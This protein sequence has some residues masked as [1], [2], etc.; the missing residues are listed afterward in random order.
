MKTN[1][2]KN[3][4]LVSDVIY[5]KKG[6]SKMVY[7]IEE[8][9]RIVSPIAAE[10]GLDLYDEMVVSSLSMHIG[11]IGEQLDKNKLSDEVQNRYEDMLPWSQI[12]KFR[13]K[14]YHHYGKM[15]N[16]EIVLIAQESIPTLIEALE[17]I[18]KEIKIELYK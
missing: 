13:D 6:G 9:K 10:Y 5:S 4:I 16:G 11:Q 1:K 12:K 7:G 18:K 17:Y 15:S 8:I 2:E 14:A 3:G